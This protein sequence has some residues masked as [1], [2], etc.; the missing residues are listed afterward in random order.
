MYPLHGPGHDINS[1][2]V[3]Q[4]QSKSMKFTWLTARGGEAGH[5]RFQVARKRPVKDKEL[6]ALV[7]NAVKQVLK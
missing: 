2:K 7:T 3:I 4:A 5:V 6:N 1:C